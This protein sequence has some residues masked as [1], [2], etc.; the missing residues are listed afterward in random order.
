MV[1]CN[2]SNLNQLD[3]FSADSGIS[4]M[5]INTQAFAASLK[6]RPLEGKPHHLL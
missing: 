3:H 1:C 4:V 5:I 2:S 6:R